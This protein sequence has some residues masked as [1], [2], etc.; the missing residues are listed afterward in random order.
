MPEQDTDDILSS[1]GELVQCV[2]A[3]ASV[4]DIVTE[5]SL[6]LVRFVGAFEQTT[7]GAAG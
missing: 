4:E 5:S 3:V 7:L 2:V 1:P 6:K